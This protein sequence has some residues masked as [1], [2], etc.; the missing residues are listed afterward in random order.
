MLKTAD[1]FQSGM[2]LQR[3]KP[4]RIWGTGEPGERVQASIQGKSADAA[5]GPDGTWMLMVPELEASEEEKLTIRTETESITLGQVAVGEVWVAGGQSNMEFH[6]HYEKHREEEYASCPNPRLR[7]FDVPEVCYDGQIEEFDYS[8][9]GIWRTA[10]KEELDYFSAA[11]YYFQKELEQCLDVPVGIVGCNWGGTTASVWMDKETLKKAG[12][13][14]LRDFEERT[15]HM[16]MDAYWKKMHGNP[17]NDQGDHFS[18]PLNQMVLPR[19]PG[20]E[21]LAAFFQTDFAKEFQRQ[22]EEIQGLLPSAVPGCLFEHMT[23]AIAPFGIRGFLWYQGESDDLPGHQA[24]YKEMLKGLIYD[25]RKLWQEKELPF[26]VVQLPG[27]ERWMESENQDWTTIRNCQEQV[28]DTMENVYLCSISDAGEQYDIHP[29]DKKVV[30]HRLALLARGHVYGEE[31]LCDA[32][33]PRRAVREKNRIV[34]AFDHAEGGL[35]V[36]GSQISALKVY[37][38]QKELS[39]QAEVE[40]ENLVLTLENDLTDPVDVE[41]AQE[42]W[43]LVNLYNQ[44]DIPAVPFSIHCE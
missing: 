13:L 32:P 36:E 14:W 6:M 10:A 21:E 7:F 41:F 38:D 26:L 29:K 3:K 43:Y 2:I 20:P 17:V 33:R 30:G 25:W 44:S 4:V 15:A 1:I 22:M 11:G 31:L 34:L 35:K 12:A 40:G 42:K 28:A 39:F 5:V 16:D 37:R 9:T 8:R 27:W 24:L 19:T 23:R 18:N